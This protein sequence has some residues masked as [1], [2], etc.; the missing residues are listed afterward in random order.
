[1]RG[2]LFRA[3]QFS[4]NEFRLVNRIV[5]IHLIRLIF[6]YTFDFLVLSKIY[7]FSI[8]SFPKNYSIWIKGQSEHSWLLCPGIRAVLF[9]FNCKIRKI[10]TVNPAKSL[11]LAVE[12]LLD[13]RDRLLGRSRKKKHQVFTCLCQ[14]CR[15]IPAA[16]SSLIAAKENLLGVSSSAADFSSGF[17]LGNNHHS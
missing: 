4:Q 10:P 1:M 17:F 7:R 3:K 13:F 8:F 2:E 14:A 6:W 9:H 12:L 16:A 5:H 11:W 15:L